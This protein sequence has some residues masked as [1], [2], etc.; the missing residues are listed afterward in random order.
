MQTLKLKLNSIAKL[1]VVTR[2]CGS[3]QMFGQ[4]V[5]HYTA[6]ITSLAAP[7]SQMQS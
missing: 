3:D 7:H 6:C 1:H 2:G 4:P 5:M